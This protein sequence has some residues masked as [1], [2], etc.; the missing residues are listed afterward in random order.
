M[1]SQGVTKLKE[2]LFDSESQRIADLQRHLDMLA[3]SDARRHAALAKQIADIGEAAKRQASELEGKVSGLSERELRERLDILR[4]IEQLFERAGTEERFTA[5]VARSLD[6]A[7]RKAE[8]E[9][10]AETAD[11]MAPL[12]VRVVK[13]EIRNS[14]D[15]LVEALYPMTGRMVKAY[16]AS[17]MKD[18]A[19]Q[20]NRRLEQNSLMLR[21]RSITTGRSMAELAMVGAQPLKVEEVF[22]IR[23]GSGELL[24]RWPRAAAGSNRD[25]VMSGTLTAINEF[26]SEAFKSDGS[27]I[28]HIDL[29]DAQVYLRTSPVHLLAAKCEGAAPQAVEQIFDEEFLSAIEGDH[30]LA[31]S[32]GG[33]EPAPSARDAVVERLARRLEQRVADKQAELAVPPLAFNPLKALA[34]IVAVPML[35]WLAWGYW[36]DYE[37]QT[38]RRAA[39]RV[40]EETAELKGFPT[41]IEVEPRGRALTMSGLAPT[42]EARTALIDRLHTALPGTQVRDQ[43]G[44]VPSN[45]SEAEAMI[46]R[47]RR[48][49]SGVEESARSRVSALEA[50][51][52]HASVLRGLDRAW[53][54][55]GQAAEDLARLDAEIALPVQ[56]ATVARV[57]GVVDEAKG[58]IAALR[59][60]VS[61]P[62]AR[63]SPLAGIEARLDAVEERLEE[64]AGDLM[65]VIGDRGSRGPQG[66]RESRSEGVLASA[67][68][69][70][71]SAERLAT[72]AIAALQANAVR[73]AVPQPAAPTP[74]ERLKDWTRDNAIFFANN[75]DYR[76]SATAE[77]QL[78]ELA[79]LMKEAR[80]FVRVVGYT[81]ERGGQS[82]NTPLSQ[83][84]AE[85]VMQALAARGVPQAQMIAIGRL[86]AIDISPST[87]P[88]SPNRRVE[89]EVGFAG[90][91]AP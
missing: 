61:A 52:V 54:R 72:A 53:R 11:A 73:R 27:G 30:A 75:S 2:L 9:R 87:G 15:E 47:V 84:R 62:Q 69:T 21:I 66:A 33:T 89:L 55:A 85:K 83:S 80:A 37:T 26:A 35:A 34:W 29:D 51:M 44:V 36:V 39:E 38:V 79:A 49:L 20:I 60:A 64:S 67:E 57:R 41:R 58:E 77:R 1:S 7:L 56:R 59:D 63:R 42:V 40:I 23:R 81:D 70:A 4:R 17:A 14:Q 28:R 8:V 74:R 76:D 24:A 18:L 45:L 22:L 82:R 32:P 46:A 5:S 6:S 48:E 91:G 90:E 68:M 88:S 50:E 16:V 19:D 71:A 43:L 78:D 86:N 10:H 25:Q 12:V 31:S 3:E 65:A 13:T